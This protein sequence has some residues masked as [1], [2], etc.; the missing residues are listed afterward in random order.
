MNRIPTDELPIF[1]TTAPAIFDDPVST[2]ALFGPVLAELARVVDI[3]QE[4]L[5]SPTPC[6]SYSVAELRRHVLAWL[7]FFAEALNDPYGQTTRIDPD[8]WDLSAEQSA[9]QVVRQAASDIEQ[10]IDAGVS[11][12][13]VVMSQ[14]RMTGSSV[15]A[16]ALGEYLVHG[17]DLATSTR[18][19]WTAAE[20]AA[21]PALEFLRSTVSP[22]YRGPE[23]GFFDQ[24]VPAPSEATVF[25]RL[26]CFAGRDPGW[27]PTDSR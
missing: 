4:Q 13:L 1:P 24:E 15:L 22:E 18:A 10:A 27:T 2:K 21:D 26:L 23:S 19:P 17:W 25:E 12:Q 6:Q 9:G 5:V 3:D 7:Q 20:Q 16:M 11:N 8:T 14:A